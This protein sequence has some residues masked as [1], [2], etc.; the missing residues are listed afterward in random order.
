MTL[1]RTDRTEALRFTGVC[2][3]TNSTPYLLCYAH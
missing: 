3:G 2:R 1:N